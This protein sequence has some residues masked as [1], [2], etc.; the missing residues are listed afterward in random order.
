MIFLSE[1][2]IYLVALKLQFLIPCEGTWLNNLSM[3]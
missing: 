1:G 2:P 3:V